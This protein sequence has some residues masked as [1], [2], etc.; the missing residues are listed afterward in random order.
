MTTAM[1]TLAHAQSLLL[2]QGLSCRLVGDPTITIRRVHTDTR[3][4]E[5]G[6]LFVALQGERYDAHTFL[7]QAIAAGAVAVIARNGTIPQ[8]QSG[9][10][11]ADTLEALQALAR[12]WR[13]QMPET[14]VL[15]AVTG[16]NGKTTVTQ[17]IRSILQA[18]CGE[19]A[20]ATAGNLNNHIGVPLT[21]LRLRSSSALTH[22]AAVLELGM[23]HPGE[24]AQ[25]AAM[26]QPTVALVINAQREHQEFMH[27]VDA[28]ARENGQVLCALSQ[29]GTAVFPASDTY[30][31]LWRSLATHNKPT[32][33]APVCMTFNATDS[34]HAPDAT[35]HITQHTWMGHYW[36]VH[37]HT[38]VGPTSFQLHMAGKHNLHNALA[39]ATAALAAGASLKAIEQGLTTFRPVSGRCQHQK[40]IVGSQTVD[41]IDDTYNAN[42]DSVRAAI[43]LLTTLPGPRGLILGDMGE[44]GESGPAFHTEIGEYAAASD[45]AQVWTVGDLSQH[46]AQAFAG[47]RYF[48]SMEALLNELQQWPACASVL[49]KG[50]RFMKM[51]RIVRR[52]QE[53]Y[54]CY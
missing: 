16:S 28:V 46:T 51:E 47:A 45:I 3:S 21:L 37:I 35:V 11:V 24:I 27:T 26:A 13:R 4:L 23:N 20:L 1:M 34:S 12:A 30:T 42:P 49:V 22:R 6:D 9:L 7:P 33:D 44:V 29:A 10:E 2:S 40:M 32:H 25:L 53:V 43:D 14:L 39:A 18:W 5:L 48:P 54:S 19:S 36:D 41:L 52:W 31:S 8:G 38:P 15:I 17:M 50:S